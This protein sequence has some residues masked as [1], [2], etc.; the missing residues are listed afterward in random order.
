MSIPMVDLQQQYQQL[1]AE[2]EPAIKTALA[3][4]HYI[5]GP[6]V[7]AFER[8][9]ADYLGVKH[10]LGVASG[11]DALHLA[12]LACGIQ[13]GDEV[14][15]PAFTFI[16]TVEAILYCGAKPVF[17]DIDENNFNLD[18]QQLENLIT[19]KTKAILPVHLYG[20]PVDM[21]Q[22][23]LIANKHGIQVIEDAAQSFG[24]NW[25]K[26]QTG[27]FGH[28]GCYSF[29]PSKN[30]SAFGDGGLIT[31]NS[32]KIYTELRA[33]RDHGSYTRYH[34]EKLG[35][36]SRLDELQAVILRIKLKYIDQYNKQRHTAAQYYSELLSDAI[37]TPQENP[38]GQHIYHQYTILH[39]QREKIQQTLKDANIA[40]AIYY[41]IP[42]HRQ[43]LFANQYADL[44]L[45]ITEKITKQCLSLPIF[46]EISKAQIETITTTINRA[47]K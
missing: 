18:L 6:N 31:T 17:I 14:I 12:L 13:A 33:L 23:M 35:Y 27:S 15:T 19:P 8:E 36:N 34:H 37:I 32:D 30:L 39:E 5:L 25:N 9:T 21:T 16:A 20:N 43:A 11:T 44:H 2:I 28:C 10:A 3:D 7:E 22:L 1:R 40:S 45:P 42:L 47:I 29:Y 46:P 26:Q 4:A 24:A 41:P 38:A